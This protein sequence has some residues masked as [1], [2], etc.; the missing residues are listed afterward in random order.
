MRA[1]ARDEPLALMRCSNNHWPQADNDPII[2]IE[3]DYQGVPEVD[4]S[5]AKLVWKGDHV[6]T[7]CPPP[8]P[9]WR[10]AVERGTPSNVLSLIHI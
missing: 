9:P 6:K 4:S 8:L 7:W 5:T 1:A 2:G 10:L 3:L